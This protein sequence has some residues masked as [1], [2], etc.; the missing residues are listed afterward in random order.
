MRLTEW[1]FTC[2]ASSS[3]SIIFQWFCGDLDQPCRIESTGSFDLTNIASIPSE[4]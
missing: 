4:S 2:F 3:L 1:C